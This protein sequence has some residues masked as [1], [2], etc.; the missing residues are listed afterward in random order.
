MKKQV[1]NIKYQVWLALDNRRL[2][3]KTQLLFA[4]YGLK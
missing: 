4:Y 3:H 1:L 2:V